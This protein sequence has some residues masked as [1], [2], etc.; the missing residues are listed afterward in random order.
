MHDGKWGLRH[1]HK[2]NEKMFTAAHINTQKTPYIFLKIPSY[3]P[4]YLYALRV[5]IYQL[6][7]AYMLPITYIQMCFHLSSQILSADNCLV[8]WLIC[9]LIGLTPFET[10]GFYCVGAIFSRLLTAP[11]INCITVFYGILLNK[12]VSH[13]QNTTLFPNYFAEQNSQITLAAIVRYLGCSN[14]PSVP[15]VLCT[16]RL[17]LLFFNY[18]TSNWII[19]FFSR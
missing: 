17:V 13:N 7:L 8:V 9:N 12:P 14:C 10:M 3:L 5:R 16:Q 18:N 1:K 19:Y 2:R 4:I 15:T 11:H 6:L